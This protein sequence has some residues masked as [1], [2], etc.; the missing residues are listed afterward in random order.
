MQYIEKIHLKRQ[1]DEINKRH[2]HTEKSNNFFFNRSVLK[3][4]SKH[5]LFFNQKENNPDRILDVR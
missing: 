5:F 4:I 2:F 3:E 1:G